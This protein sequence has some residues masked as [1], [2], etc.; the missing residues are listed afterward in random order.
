M[1][2]HIMS[3]SIIAMAGLLFVCCPANAQTKIPAAGG[4]AEAEQILDT[5]IDKIW[6]LSDLHW[7]KGE[8]NH[9][10]NVCKIVA[11]ADPSNVEA[12][13]NAGWL[14]W[15]MDRDQEAVAVYQDGIK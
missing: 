11:A 14:L 5:V 10:V 1:R 9:I 8:Y 2:S 6:V 13:A 4:K 7:H 12:F 3:I 15:S